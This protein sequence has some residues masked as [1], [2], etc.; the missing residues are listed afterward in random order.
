MRTIILKKITKNDLIINFGID[1]DK[2]P[3]RKH[4]YIRQS[5]TGDYIWIKNSIYTPG[6]ILVN[7]VK[8]NKFKFIDEDIRDVRPPKS[9]L[10]V[11]RDMEYIDHE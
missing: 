1:P 8:G 10:T 2:V 11:V 7:L 4:L 3:T 9:K 6:R 5:S